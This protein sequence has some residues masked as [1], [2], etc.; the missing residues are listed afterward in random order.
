MKWDIQ[1]MSM[2]SL[3][4][5]VCTPLEVWTVIASEAKQSQWIASSSSLLAMTTICNGVHYESHVEE[6]LRIC[7]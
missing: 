3:R 5:S 1:K 2:L 6:P 7:H 4:G